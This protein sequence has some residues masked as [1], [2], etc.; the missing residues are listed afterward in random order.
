MRQTPRLD[1]ALTYGCIELE[2]VRHDHSE[3]EILR[4]EQ[5]GLK[6]LLANP[7]KYG[8]LEKRVA[9]KVAAA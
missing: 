9:T 6:H 2:R 3:Y 8:M 7:A 4:R 1:G 5:A